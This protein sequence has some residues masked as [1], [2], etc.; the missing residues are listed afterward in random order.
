[1]TQNTFEP[2]HVFYSQ[3][4][5]ALA[6]PYNSAFAECRNS[7]VVGIQTMKH[8]I[9]ENPVEKVQQARRTLLDVKELLKGVNGWTA[10]ISSCRSAIEGTM[11]KAPS[12]ALEQHADMFRDD[13]SDSGKDDGDW[14]QIGSDEEIIT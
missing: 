8:A 3:A 10:A 4:V 1:M 13:K 9:A 2:A 14:E 5:V 6:D 12:A 11:H 7:S